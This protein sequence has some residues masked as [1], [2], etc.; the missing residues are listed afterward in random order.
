MQ[1]IKWIRACLLLL[2]F[3]IGMTIV[4]I[5]F[6][7]D[8]YGGGSVDSDTNEDTNT[9]TS[10][11]DETGNNETES[12]PTESLDNLANTTNGYLADVAESY[13]TGQL[14]TK[15]VFDINYALY[16]TARPEDPPVGDPQSD[17]IK[18]HG[19]YFCSPLSGVEQ[20]GFPNT[21]DPDNPPDML[22]QHGD[23]KL[24]SLLA[25]LQYNDAQ[26][27]VADEL[28]KNLINPFPDAKI[29]D[30]V[31]DPTAMSKRTNKEKVAEMMA[32]QAALTV[33]RHSLNHMFGNRLK[34]DSTGAV[35][36]KMQI[37]ADESGA[38]FQ[39]NAWYE[40]LKTNTVGVDRDS[41]RMSA[42][43]T[44]LQVQQYM[45]MERI[46]AILAVML[47]Q[48]VNSNIGMLSQLGELGQ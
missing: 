23:I 41:A 8:F 3:S 25:P 15:E 39:Q 5:A 9:Q 37:M 33:A 45:Q 16:R 22:L 28:I 47:A 19:A 7:Q 1:I 17:F 13:A 43:Q 20:K 6:A 44:W 36:S 26:R 42:F 31:K 32:A 24:S 34:D 27:K 30:I 2:A 11:N 29:R 40:E 38:R 48:Q 4:S 14:L 12:P 21:C 35:S 10:S 18:Y 46:E